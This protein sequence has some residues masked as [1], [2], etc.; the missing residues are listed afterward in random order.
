M[1]RGLGAEV[2]QYLLGLPNCSRCSDNIPNR[3]PHPK[4]QELGSQNALLLGKQIRP[5]LSNAA[6]WRPVRCS[7]SATTLNIIVEAA[8]S[9]KHANV[10]ADV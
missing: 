6:P 3:D 2:V 1:H 10:P 4:V 9:A 5:F 8:Y 7:F